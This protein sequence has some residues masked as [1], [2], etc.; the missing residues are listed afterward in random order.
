[1]RKLMQHLASWRARARASLQRALT[2]PRPRGLLAI[3]LTLGCLIGTPLSGCYAGYG[4]ETRS[5][6]Y[7][8][9]GGGYYGARS[10]YYRHS[11]PPPVVVYPRGHYHDH[12]NRGRSY[13]RAPAARPRY[14]DRGHDHGHHH[15]R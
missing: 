9:G 6:G 1:M 4:Y 14:R 13:Y 5:G 15:Y 3:A 12:G 7:Y 11:A 8:R 10:G 2:G